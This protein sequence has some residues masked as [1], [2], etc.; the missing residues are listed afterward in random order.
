MVSGVTLEAVERAWQERKAAVASVGDGTNLVGTSSALVTRH[1]GAMFV[2]QYRPRPDGCFA[3]DMVAW[4]WDK[5][6]QT[7]R[8]V[9]DQG[10]KNVLHTRAMQ[11]GVVMPLRKAA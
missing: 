9:Q 10:M 1:S 3:Q 4:R 5:Y 6:I 2:F 11:S 7:W 8:E